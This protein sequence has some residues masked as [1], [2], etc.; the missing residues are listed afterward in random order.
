MPDRQST[1]R[2][3]LV[4]LLRLFGTSSLFAVVFVVAPES[5]MQAIHGALGMGDLPTEPV[6]GYLAR[7]TS[8]LYAILGG[9]FWVMSFDPIRCLP[10]LRYLGV[11]LPLFGIALYFIDWAEGLPWLWRIWEGTA[12]LG[13]GLLIGWLARGLDDR[14]LGDR[15]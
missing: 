9:S 14:P 10:V 4:A 12:V 6:V 7:S 5:W 2:A 1:R 11:A 15:G 13:F 8:A 3:V